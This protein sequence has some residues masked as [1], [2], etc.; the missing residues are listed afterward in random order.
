MLQ[1]SNSFNIGKF[2]F[3]KTYLLHTNK[4]QII[5]LAILIKRSSKQSSLMVMPYSEEGYNKHV[6][7]YTL[8]ERLTI[9][10]PHLSFPNL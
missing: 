4:F 7:E 5:T 3:N 6:Y 10:N 1:H 8:R 2:N 9:I